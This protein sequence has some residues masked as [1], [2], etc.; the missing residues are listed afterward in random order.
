MIR[1][2]PFEPGN[3]L[4]RGRPK[5]SR[6]KSN[7][8]V[9]QRLEENA[10]PLVVRQLSAAL[11]DCVK[12][13]TWCLDHLDRLWEKERLTGKLKLPPIRT[14]DNIAEACD[15]VLNAVA[16]HKRTAAD[17]QALCA[18]LG[19]RRNTIQAQE[20]DRRLEALERLEKVRA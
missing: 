6:N 7:S 14:L 13:R 1:G 10:E 8:V 4:G 9:R 20:Q 11:R 15:I 19:E 3:K 2:R 12:S 16:N 18:M 5:G 17:G